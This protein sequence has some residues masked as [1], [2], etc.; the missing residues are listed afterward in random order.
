MSSCP[1]AHNTGGGL[2]L[3]MEVGNGWKWDPGKQGML[4]SLQWSSGL[5]SKHELSCGKGFPAPQTTS[6]AFWM[7]LGA[8]WSWGRWTRCS[9]KSLPTQTQD[10]VIHVC[11]SSPSLW[12]CLEMAVWD[13]WDHCLSPSGRSICKQHLSL[14]LVPQEPRA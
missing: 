4:R 9:S 1:M 13:L 8:P 3:G 2:F 10:S 14:L 6:I 7:G 5:F 12:G 11:Q